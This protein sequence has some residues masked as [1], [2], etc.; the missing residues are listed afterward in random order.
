MGFNNCE[1]T[2]YYKLKRASLYSKKINCEKW[3]L[4]C[5]N[6][7]PNS[8]Y[9]FKRLALRHFFEIGIE[10]CRGGPH[11]PPPPPQKK[12]THMNFFGKTY[13][14]LLI[15]PTPNFDRLY[16]WAKV[17][18]LEKSCSKTTL[19]FTTYELF[20]YWPKKIWELLP[21]LFVIII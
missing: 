13:A 14:Y 10:I 9:C 20:L 5:M 3:N 11:V 17:Q 8:V 16:F 19:V 15:W 7:L 4:N 1:K 18:A 2:T 6:I 21:T 12:K